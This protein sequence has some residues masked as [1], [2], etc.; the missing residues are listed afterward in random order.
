MKETTIYLIRHSEQVKPIEDLYD[1]KL[2]QLQNEMN[3]LSKNGELLAKKLSE[4]KE[5]QNIDILYSSHYERA[6]A[7]AKYIAEQNNIKM[8]IDTRLR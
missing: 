6:I 7:T 2:S 3:A 4:E 1:T 5:L 8:N